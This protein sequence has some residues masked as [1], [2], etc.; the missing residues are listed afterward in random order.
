LLVSIPY[1]DYSPGDLTQIEQFVKFGNSLLLLD[2]FGY[3]NNVLERLG[4]GVRF[5][6]TVLLDPLFSYKNQYLP[7]ITDFSE[8]LKKN[9][10]KSITLNHAVALSQVEPSRALAWSSSSSFLDSNANGSKDP[11]ETAGPLAVAA[12]YPVGRGIV[13]LVSDPSLIINTMV[14]QDDNQKFIQYL[15]A[16]HGEPQK[17]LLDRS[18]LTKSPLDVSKMNLE[19][20]QNVLANP[21]VLIAVV[22]LILIMVPLLVRKTNVL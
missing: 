20:A 7:R 15:T 4:L 10:V 21:Y 6:N 13:I 16:R 2:D 17:I 1:L 3:G 18:H 14:G 12:E 8:D 9:G 19:G 22:A 5:E 11:D